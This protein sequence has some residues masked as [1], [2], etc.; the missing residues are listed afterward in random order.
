MLFKRDSDRTRDP[1]F[2]WFQLFTSGSV[3]DMFSQSNFRRDS[4]RYVHCKYVSVYTM[5]CLVHVDVVIYVLWTVNVSVL[6]FFGG[7]EFSCTNPPI[8]YPSPPQTII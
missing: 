6:D 4:K 2:H 1:F 3:E 8:T 5:I 7:C